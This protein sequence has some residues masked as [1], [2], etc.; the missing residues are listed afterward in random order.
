MMKGNGSGSN[1]CNSNKH[2]NIVVVVCNIFKTRI[3]V[4][5]VPF[6]AVFVFVVVANVHT[7]TIHNTT[8]TL[9]SRKGGTTSH[10][11]GTTQPILF[12]LRF[13]FSKSK[14]FIFLSIHMLMLCICLFSLSLYNHWSDR[15]LCTITKLE[16]HL[17][18]SDPRITS[19]ATRFLPSHDL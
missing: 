8:L 18:V 4:S 12:S 16:Q 17:F 5:L 13:L 6:K 7:K 1:S 9:K 10:T 19:L 2:N 3:Q 15:C 11:G 14:A